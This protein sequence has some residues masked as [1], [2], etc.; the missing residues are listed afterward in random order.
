[1]NYEAKITLAPS[2][3]EYLTAVNEVGIVSKIDVSDGTLI[4]DVEADDLWDAHEWITG[5]ADQLDSIGLGLC[6]IEKPTE[7]EN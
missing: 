1:M 5:L 2:V 4:L 6:S 7:K 3:V